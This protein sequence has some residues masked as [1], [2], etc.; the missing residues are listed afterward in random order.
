MSCTSCWSERDLFVRGMQTWTTEDRSRRP[1]TVRRR[2]DK[3]RSSD[4]NALPALTDS[5]MQCSSVR[6]GAIDSKQALLEQSFI[7]EGR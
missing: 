6:V 1:A 3:Q 5:E 2:C 7:G 4:D